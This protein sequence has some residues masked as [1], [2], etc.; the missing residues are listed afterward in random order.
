MLA[1]NTTEPDQPPKWG[2][3]IPQQTKWQR[4]EWFKLLLNENCS[5]TE[6][7]LAK[8]DKG[9]KGYKDKMDLDYIRKAIQDIP[10]GKHPVDLVTD[11]LKALFQ[12]AKT[13]LMEAYPELKE[14]LAGQK[15]SLTFHLTVP[16]VST[17]LSIIFTAFI[18]FTCLS[19]LE[20]Y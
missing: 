9:L 10:A 1:Y 19:F 17:Y 16:A 8:V 15:T 2:F 5:T 3:D 14:E 18:Y 7:L 6:E 4:V 12:H 13:R 11:F 20:V